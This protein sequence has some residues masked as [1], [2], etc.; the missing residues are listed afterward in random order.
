MQGSGSA[1]EVY[2]RALIRETDQGLASPAREQRGGSAE[3]LAYSSVQVI[4]HRRAATVRAGATR[5]ANM[6]RLNETASSGYPMFAGCD[7]TWPGKNVG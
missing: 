3:A 7:P 6:E 4:R 5:T 1:D 2:E